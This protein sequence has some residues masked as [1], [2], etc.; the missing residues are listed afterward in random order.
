MIELNRIL[1]DGR[2]GDVAAFIN[3]NFEKVRVE[4]LK[5]RHA[6][7]LT[8][9]K[10][11][12]STESRFLE[13]Y[14]T[15]KTGEYAFV[16]TPW[17]GTVYEWQDTAWVDT[18]V[19]PQLG[20]A[21]FIELLKR[22]IDNETIYWDAGEEVIRSQGGGGG[23]MFTVT[24]D[25]DE[26]QGI[27]GEILPAK[28]NKVKQGDTLTIKIQPKDGYEVLRVNVD[29]VNQGAVT[30]YTF[31]NVQEDHTM[32]VW[33]QEETVTNPTDFLERSDLS[34]TYY[35]SLQD[36]FNAVKASYP[37]G[38]TQDVTISCIKKAE[39]K[40][41]GS[42]NKFLATLSGFNHGTVHTLTIDGCGL[43]TVN[44]NS[45]GGIYLDKS[46]N[47]IFRNIDFKNCGNNA[48]QY[49][50]E[51]TC[52]IYCMGS[53]GQYIRNIYV[54]NCRI[55]GLNANRNIKAW[56]SFIAKCSENVYIVD[57]RFD[58]NCGVSVKLV[59]S[60]FT[61]LIRNYVKAD[62][63]QGIIGHPALCTCTNG[64]ALLAEDNE[65]TGDTAEYYFFATNV[66]QIDLRR[67]RFE[68]GRGRAM[69]VS[70]KNAVRSVNIESNLFINMLNAPAY[71]WTHEYFSL[72]CEVR[73][74]NILNNTA[75]MGGNDWQQW[76]M[77]A[78]SAHVHVMNVYNNIFVNPSSTI[79]VRGCT[80]GKVDALHSGCNIYQ[81]RQ[82]N[83]GTS[84]DSLLSTV[85]LAN[86]Y[87][88]S[89]LNA[90]GQETG[91]VL[92]PQTDKILEIQHG[93]DSY[94]LLP[95]LAYYSDM[96][97]LPFADIAYRSKA[98]SGNT[99]GCYNLGG[100]AIDESGDSG[101][102]YAG[103]DITES[104]TFDHSAQYATYA[105]NVLV[106]KHKTLSRSRFIRM[107]VTGGQHTFLIL[108]RYGMLSLL[109]RLDA[110]GEYIAD[111]LYTINID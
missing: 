102:G 20:E 97:H 88:I 23:E 89:S 68:G 2:W 82:K 87:T 84:E 64:Y 7:I 15:G 81:F 99:C 98:D 51:E 27:R 58:N 61:S 38:L 71:G 4:L 3:A 53:A 40:Y 70:S 79:P 18:G 103:E 60:R 41:S 94:G 22:H 66:E 39:E 13:K 109:P 52:A 36:V 9:C 83:A 34:G 105:D 91:S 108:G 77:R 111:E 67:N 93:V 85:D 44:G 21:V 75:Y 92:V 8:F 50:P 106:L 19:V 69:E 72:D 63:S 54:D 96:G 57:S 47:V 78:G 33:F 6:S 65:L 24:V 35:S 28:I 31:E 42:G 45:L 37:D 10:G 48:E 14:P 12:F 100:I 30:E 101:I 74:L 1:S 46:D 73:E 43:L 107:T 59:D 11:Y 86:T 95:G 32:Y 17:P 55:D 76:F 25:M 110:A 62:Y 80:M 56:Y 26:T 29:K 5:L 49:A 16:G 90:Q 104:A